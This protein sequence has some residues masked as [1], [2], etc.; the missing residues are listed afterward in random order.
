MKSSLI[1][2]SALGTLILKF[3]KALS[4]LLKI[5]AIYSYSK[6]ALITYIMKYKLKLAIFI[7]S[8][9]NPVNEIQDN[10]IKGLEKV[11]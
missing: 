3:L 6:R 10:I 8:S 7:H 5:Y 11:D 1:D 9:G 2:Y 4:H